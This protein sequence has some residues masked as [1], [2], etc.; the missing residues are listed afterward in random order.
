MSQL[1]IGYVANHLKDY[2]DPVISHVGGQAVMWYNCRIEPRCHCCN[3][4]MS[5]LLQVE[6]SY[7]DDFDRVLLVF[8]CLNN[9][10]E[11]EKECKDCKD[12]FRVFRAR[13][14]Q[15]LN[16]ECRYVTPTNEG[17]L[18][19]IQFA[20]SDTDDD[21][22]DSF[23][24]NVDGLETPIAPSLLRF[25]KSADKFIPSAKS[26][27]EKVE[28][29]YDENDFIPVGINSL[30]CY[31]VYCEDGQSYKLLDDILE[32]NAN[33]K[34]LMDDSNIPEEATEECDTFAVRMNK[35]MELFPG[36]IFRYQVGQKPLWP[37]KPSESTPWRDVILGKSQPP[38]CQ[39]CGR[40]RVCEL[41]IL[42]SLLSSF[43]SKYWFNMNWDTLCVYTCMSDC[44]NQNA[45]EIIEEWVM[46]QR[47]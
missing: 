40:K 22:A 34:Y 41:Q 13:N 20:E 9:K 39:L 33:R 46:Y 47:V 23:I 26:K 16:S 14:P 44:Q 43:D 38:P 29:D 32:Q 28:V 21:T 35:H 24:K 27:V 36:H 8:C 30:P 5:C 17:V 42:S 18:A 15:S 3:S 25:I 4:S 12:S 7:S 6:C 31:S 45:C 1:T 2:N 37:S 10:Q 11:V 19:K